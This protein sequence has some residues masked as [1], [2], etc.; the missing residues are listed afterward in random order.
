MFWL[1]CYDLTRSHSISQSFSE[2]LRQADLS[3]LAL[4]EV[5]VRLLVVLSGS[6]TYQIETEPTLT[7]FSDSQW[8]QS[9]QC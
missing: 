6:F 7:R 9:P 1:Q 4:R 3:V 5:T 2:H 8:I